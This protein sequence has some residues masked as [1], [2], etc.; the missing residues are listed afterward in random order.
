M[1]SL[2]AVPLLFMIDARSMYTPRRDVSLILILTTKH[3]LIL[4]LLR[5]LILT[6]SNP[7]FT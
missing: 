5:T 3:F 7:K 1:E 2:I 4:T 6:L